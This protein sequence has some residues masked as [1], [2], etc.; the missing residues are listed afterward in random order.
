MMYGRGYT[1]S[2]FSENARGFGYGFMNNGWGMLVVIAVLLIIALLIYIF[3]HNRNKKVSQSSVFEVL[4]MKYV[5]GE[6]SEEEYLKRKEV[7]N[8]K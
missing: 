1:G 4:K 5:Q 3:V 2:G 6:I 7:I 8:R